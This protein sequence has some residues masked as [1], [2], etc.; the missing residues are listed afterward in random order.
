LVNAVQDIR[1]SCSRDPALGGYFPWEHFGVAGLPKIP[2]TGDRVLS[3]HTGNT[4]RYVFAK[5]L[6]N[7]KGIRSRHDS[8]RRRGD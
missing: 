1:I 8:R 7:T 5:V 2:A 4:S 3:E 6:G